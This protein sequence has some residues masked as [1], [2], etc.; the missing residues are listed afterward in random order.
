MN[1]DDMWRE[2]E[3][4]ARYQGEGRDDDPPPSDRLHTLLRLWRHLS[5]DDRLRFLRWIRVED[6]RTR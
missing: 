2:A 1:R 4:Y 3:D 5:P 6:T